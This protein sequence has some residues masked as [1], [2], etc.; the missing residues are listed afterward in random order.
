KSPDFRAVRRIGHRRRIQAP[1]R[2]ILAAA[3][4]R[5]CFRACLEHDWPRELAGW[6]AG[7]P[8]ECA[9]AQISRGC[10][11]AGIDDYHVPVA[12]DYDAGERVIHLRIKHVTLVQNGARYRID[13]EPI[14]S[15]AGSRRQ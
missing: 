9:Y 6:I 7:T 15:I 4:A 3:A 11:R 2:R 5:V 12:I 1:A 8:V 14:E 13:L 10:V